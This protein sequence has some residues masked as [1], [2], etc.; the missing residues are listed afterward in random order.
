MREKINT[1]NWLE[2]LQEIEQTY[3][4]LDQEIA[5]VLTNLYYTGYTYE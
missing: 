3:S 5:K 4:Y 2:T 1:E